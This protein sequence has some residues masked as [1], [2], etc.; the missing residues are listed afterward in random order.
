MENSKSKNSLNKSDIF[1]DNNLLINSHYSNFYDCKEKNDTTINH[2]SKS[3]DEI[4]K[5]K[6]KLFK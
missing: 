5:D 2:K 4:K 3:F 1:D 6:K